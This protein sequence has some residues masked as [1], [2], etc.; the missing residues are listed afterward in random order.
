MVL[1]HLFLPKT[2]RACRVSVQS[3]LT[4]IDRVGLCFELP[5]ICLGK[6]IR[7]DACAEDLFLYRHSQSWL[8]QDYSTY[9]L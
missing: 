4:G 9:S 6:H 3:E 5:W 8:M 7:T 2:N 1:I